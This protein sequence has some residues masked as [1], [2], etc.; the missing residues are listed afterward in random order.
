MKLA[1][2]RY[3]L[4]L[5]R[6]TLEYYFATGDK[7]VINDNLDPELKENRSTFVTLSIDGRLRGCIGHLEAIQTVYLD[8]IDNTLGAALSDN[9]FLPLTKEELEKIKIEISV[10]TLPD[11]IIYSSVSDLLSKIEINRYGVIIEKNGHEA[12]YLPQVWMEISN[13]EDFLSSLC[14]KAGLS[15]EEWKKGDLNVWTYEVEAFA[16]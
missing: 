10:L 4:K 8:V 2:Q 15:S 13:K 5:A 12:T 1:N 3:L 7:L 11:K 9:R 14:H 16:E 6:Q